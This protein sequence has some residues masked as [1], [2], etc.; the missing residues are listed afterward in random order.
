MNFLTARE[1]EQSDVGIKQNS[2]R[3]TNLLIIEFGIKYGYFSASVS[4]FIFFL[5]F[6]FYFF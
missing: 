6:Y 1:C 2:F 4:F 5:I 3:P